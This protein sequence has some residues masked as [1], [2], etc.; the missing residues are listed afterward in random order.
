VDAVLIAQTI[1]DR[2]SQ[3]ATIIDERRRATSERRRS[4]R[5][6][7]NDEMQALLS[8]FLQASFPPALPEVEGLQFEALYLSCGG[9]IIGG[10]WYDALALPDG[11]VAVALGDVSGHG[12][13]AAALMGKLRYSMR[14]VTLRANALQSGGAASVLQIVEDGL[15]SEHPDTSA[16]AFLG[17]I[18]PDRTRMQYATAGH[19]PPLVV[20]ASRETAW[21]EGGDTPLG[22]GNGQ[23]RSEHVV[24]LTDARGLIL[25]T[26]GVVEAG[27]DVLEGL[28]RLRK[29]VEDPD[30]QDAKDL[31]PRIVEASLAAPPHDD[32][33]MLAV[34]FG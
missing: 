1:V 32:I 25:Y 30:V 12:V 20:K 19:P 5:A 2:W 23:L 27:R 6:A 33:A 24:D 14:V 3:S 16:T 26:D 10:D 17:I 11:S 29:T 18:S 13:E 31:L 9:S 22:W 15:R 28:E 21:L 4:E 7:L 34:K 8:S